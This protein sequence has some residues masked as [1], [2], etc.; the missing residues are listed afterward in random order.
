MQQNEGFL[1]M[2][3][4]TLNSDFK[5]KFCQNTVLPIYFLII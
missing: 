1:M 5:I 2:C 4:V 3:G